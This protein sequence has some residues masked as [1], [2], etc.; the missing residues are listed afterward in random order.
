VYIEFKDDADLLCYLK[1]IASSERQVDRDFG[2]NIIVTL[3]LKYIE[4]IVGEAFKKREILPKFRLEQNLL[5]I[6]PEFVTMLLAKPFISS[7]PILK[8]I[9]LTYFT[10]GEKGKN[11]KSPTSEATDKTIRGEAVVYWAKPYAQWKQ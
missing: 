10:C 2:I 5:L 3:R 4:Y 11:P 8:N 9:L 6:T 1:D 7:Q